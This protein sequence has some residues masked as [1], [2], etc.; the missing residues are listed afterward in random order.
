M[1]TLQVILILVLFLLIC[2]G[3]FRMQKRHITFGKRVLLALA[4]GIAFGLVIQMIYGTDATIVEQSMNWINIAG[5]GFVSLLQM[6]VIPIVFIAILRAFTNSTFTN[7]FGKIG[8]L[9]IGIL[10]GTVVIAGAIGIASAWL[11]NLDGMEITQ[12][13]EEAEAISNIEA[14]TGDVEDQTLPDMIISMI[15]SNIFEDFSQGRDTSVIA[16]VLFTIIAGI[17]FMGV[18]RKQPDQA[19]IF[20]TGVESIFAIIMRIVTLIL[21]LT[22]YGILALMT[23]KAATSDIATF[24]DLGL[25][26][27]ASYLAI[28]AMFI[29]HMLLMKS[30]GLSP[31]TYIRKAMPPLIFGF[32]S[33]SSAGTLPLTIET[34][35]KSL[36]VPGGIADISGAFSV[37]IGQNGCAGIYPAM[38][39]VMAA[40]TAGIDPFTPSFILMLLAVVAIGSFGVAGVGGGATFASLIVLSTMNLPVAI[41][42][43]L[44]SIEPLID[45]ART[46][47]NISGGMTAGVLTAKFTKSLDEDMFDDKNQKLNKENQAAAM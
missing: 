47:L 5:A 13:Q 1:N 30:V 44:I 18:K 3:L 40:P 25:F 35:K 14:Q 11:F 24:I 9:S 34:E 33:R 21:R 31:M 17:A 6:L 43:L 46:A 2:Y 16:V 28:I 12:G 27:I 8:G 20:A 26:I 4:I 41:V 37:T 36:G 15:P 39:A 7:G 32:S 42:G 19:E 29:V 23:T 10:V 22:P 38:L 45:M